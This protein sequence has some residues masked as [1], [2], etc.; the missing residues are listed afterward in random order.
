MKAIVP[1]LCLIILFGCSQD[2]EISSQRTMQGEN[3]SIEQVNETFNT[4]PVITHSDTDKISTVHYQLQNADFRSLDKRSEDL[5]IVDADDAN[6]TTAQVAKLREKSVVLSYLS[7]GE[8]EDHRSYWE[9]WRVGSPSFIDRENNLRPGNYL[10]KYWDGNWQKV[11][12]SKLDEIIALGYSGIYLDK[13]DAYENYE[14]QEPD[15]KDEMVKFVKMLHDHALSK[16]PGFLVFA[17]NGEELYGRKDF[18]NSID[19]AGAEDV[20]FNGDAEVETE[21]SL[22]RI[23]KLLRIA[24]DDKPVIVVDYPTI[25]EKVCSFYRKCIT[26]PFICAAYW[27]SLSRNEALDCE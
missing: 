23:G 4:S 13:V 5:F 2:I 24:E 1:L 12:L 19:G 7:I 26:R 21:I 18:K 11:V 9:G 3:T 20:Y 22:L 15:A 6:L 17:Q 25:N 16:N 10:V 8:A 14:R 27:R